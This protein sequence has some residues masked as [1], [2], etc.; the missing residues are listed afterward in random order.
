[1]KVF[2][3]D[4][5]HESVFAELDIGEIDAVQQELLEQLAFFLEDQGVL[6]RYRRMVIAKSYIRKTDE[7]TGDSSIVF[8]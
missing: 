7:D 6:N 8:E 4:E 3:H 5:K 1:M 2:L